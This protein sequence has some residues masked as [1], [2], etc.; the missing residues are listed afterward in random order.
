[1]HFCFLQSAKI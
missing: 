1:L